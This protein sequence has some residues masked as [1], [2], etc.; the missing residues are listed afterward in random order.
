MNYQQAVS[1]TLKVSLT[2]ILTPNRRK[3]ISEARQILMY[4]YKRD[5]GIAAAGRILKRNHGS[6]FYGAMKI[7]GLISVNDQKT[8]D[9]VEKIEALVQSKHQISNLDYQI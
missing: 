6:V 5:M 1:E 4:F 2:Q 9:I 3:S 8:I 7:E